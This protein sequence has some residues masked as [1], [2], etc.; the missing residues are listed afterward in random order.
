MLAK[1]NFVAIFG[2]LF[3]VLAMASMVSA[4]V[5]LKWSQESVLVNEGQKACLTYSV[6]NPW[7]DTSYV[8]IGVSAELTPV[9]SSQESEQKSVP[10]NTPSSQAIPI[11]FCFQVPYVYKRDCLV[12]DYIC[13]QSCSEP[14]KIYAGDVVVETIPSPLTVQGTG[15]SAT[16][17]SISAPLNVKIQCNPHGK[18]FTPIYVLLALISLTIVLILIIRKYRKPKVDR[19]KEALRKLKEKIKREGSTKQKRK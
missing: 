2:M 16:S 8:Q 12:G 17:M 6:Y 7:P 3:L 9:L 14:Q 11:K 5:G 18:D 13:A 1:K 10:A 4:G 15:G 19:E